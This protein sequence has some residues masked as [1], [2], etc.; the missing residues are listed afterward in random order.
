MGGRKKGSI[1]NQRKPSILFRRSADTEEEDVTTNHQQKRIFFRPAEVVQ[2]G[3]KKGG[4][5]WVI[6]SPFQM[7]T[8]ALQRGTD[9][10]A[11]WYV[12]DSQTH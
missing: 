5:S 7:S 1:R 11:K 10:L 6:N 8:D 3:R 12:G 2:E 9:G 4:E